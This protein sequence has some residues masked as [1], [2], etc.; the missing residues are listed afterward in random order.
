MAFMAL[1]VPDWL[2]WLLLLLLLPLAGAAH[3]ARSF[4]EREFPGHNKDKS[5][6]RRNRVFLLMP[7]SVSGAQEAY[8]VIREE[9]TRLKLRPERVDENT[10]SGLVVREIVT[11]IERAEFIVCDL[12]CS[13]PNVYYE[14]GLAHG[15]GNHALNILL[16]AR[17]GTVIHFDVSPLRVHYYDS[18]DHLRLIVASNLAR[19]L[20]LTREPN[21]R[22][23]RPSR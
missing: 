9:C 22:R 19:M 23:S 7:F 18:A 21:N 3:F 4:Y 11:Q 6:F 10:G 8:D 2:S 14:L 20:Q 1:P 5:S 17:T 13:R 12:T 15:L 16:I